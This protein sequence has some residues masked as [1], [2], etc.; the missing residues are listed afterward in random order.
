MFVISTT[1]VTCSA[2][3]L[4]QVLVVF[5]PLSGALSLAITTKVPQGQTPQLALCHSFVKV[6]QNQRKRPGSDRPRCSCNIE[7]IN[8]YSRLFRP[9]Q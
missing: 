8:E 9:L 6:E 2:L 7:S 4:F 1:C 5:Q 3:A